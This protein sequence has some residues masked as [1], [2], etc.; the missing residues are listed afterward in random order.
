MIGIA[1]RNW[2]YYLIAVSMLIC[3]GWT[4]PSEAQT[5]IA[6]TPMANPRGS[7]T[8]TLLPSGRVLVAGGF[9][10]PSGFTYGGNIA[11]ATVYAGALIFDSLANSW[12]SAGSM[13]TARFA[14]SATLL[15]DGRVLVAGGTN[16]SGQVTATAE[17]YDPVAN[18][19]SAVGS[20]STPRT[21]HSATLLPGGKVLV[22]GGADD[23]FN[24]IQTAEIF[25]PSTNQWSAAGTLAQ[26]RAFHTSTLLGDGTV[27]AIGGA[28]QVTLAG[29]LYSVVT[30][31]ASVEAYNPA[32]NTWSAAGNLLGARGMH[33]ATWMP[34]GKILVV[35]GHSDASTS[36]STSELFDPSTL[37][38]VA[39]ATLNY[40]RGQQTANLL[41]NGTLLVTG[42]VD[43]GSQSVCGYEIYDPVAGSWSKQ[44]DS[45]GNCWYS[46]TSILLPSG[47]VISIG[48]VAAAQPCFGVD[49]ITCGGPV[50]FHSQ[51]GAT[52]FDPAAPALVSSGSLAVGR[53]EHTAS[54]LASGQVLVVGGLTG[55][56]TALAITGTSELFDP[57]S[58][59]WT[60][61]GSLANARYAHTA[62]VLF[63]GTVLVAGGFAG[64][65]LATASAETY[66]PSGGTWSGAGTMTA[67]RGFHT[68]TLL[69]NGK[70]LAAGGC[71][72]QTTCTGLS[73]AELFDP[74]SGAWSSTGALAAAR[75]AHSA[76]LLPNGKVLVAGGLDA[77][78]AVLASAELFDPVSGTWSGAGSLTTARYF[79]TASLMPDGSVVV[80]GG[81][82]ANANFPLCGTAERY[83]PATNTWTAL[84][85]T[86]NSERSDHAAIV[87]PSGRLVLVGGQAS[88]AGIASFA[89]TLD[90]YG[91]SATGVAPWSVVS[92]GPTPVS[93]PFATATL[94]LSGDILVAGGF[95]ASNILATGWIL[96]SGLAYPATRQPAM[97]PPP[98]SVVAGTD[99]SLAGSGFTGDS[100]ASGGNGSGNSA[101]DLPVATMQRLDNGQITWL[102]GV[103]FGATCLDIAAVAGQSPGPVALS[104]V[105]N[106]VPSQS[107]ALTL[108]PA[109]GTG[110]GSGAAC[111]T[112]S[113]GGG[114]SGGGS[115]GGGSSGGSSSGNGSSSGG[116]GGG[117]A[118]SATGRPDFGLVLLMFGAALARWRRRQ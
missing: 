100:E 1:G 63:D 107:I 73:S 82:T 55:T 91:V 26:A 104:V 57:T 19:W 16:S 53:A 68:A 25:D 37:A 84:P 36:L 92:G 14:H 77:N 15:R 66:S 72:V 76:I 7:H 8:A 39:A 34:S 12:A 116:G 89:E 3:G 42:G 79:H 110:A 97:S 99:L 6:A 98:S 65:G 22:S 70:V 60:P 27:L 24:A 108:Q 94:L 18:A 83:D 23:N 117:C 5:S 88:S 56:A 103:S 86:M 101:S 106:G 48:G 40:S 118:I 81:S 71:A 58:R 50:A 45:G 35:G 59:Q 32:T 80:V 69:P 21:L 67:A 52:V 9:A 96:R 113:A 4:A 29:G 51:S 17:V 87:L 30:S 41:P 115:S 54:R 31:L 109:N 2:T 105:V 102:G 85:T 75:A 62:N 10:Y 44:F 74:A 93:E 43:G 47:R 46:H 78:G 28:S 90:P 111:F 61:S 64:S 114:S 95:G 20:L 112:K 11:G 38:S 13:S 49:F 33:T